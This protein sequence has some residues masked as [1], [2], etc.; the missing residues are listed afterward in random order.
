MTS[1]PS[2]VGLRIDNKYLIEAELGSG[3]MATVY[4]ATRLL[5]GDSVAIK[6]LHPGQVDDRQSVERFRREAQAAARLKHTNV[7]PIYDFGVASDGLVYLVME[8]VEGKSLRDLLSEQGS[9][10]P[11][12]HSRNN[13]AGVFGTRS[14]P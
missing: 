11:Q 6:V 1:K 5:I 10:A 13:N 12:V 14:S 4:Q 8:L 9:F 3:G 2:R 7:V